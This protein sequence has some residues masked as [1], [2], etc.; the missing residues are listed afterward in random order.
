MDV[1]GLVLHS[2]SGIVCGWLVRR[3]LRDAIGCTASRVVV[4]VLGG[5]L[6]A[7]LMERSLPVGPIS[8]AGAM[9]DAGFA[10]VGSLGAGLGGAAA[11]A[12]LVLLERHFNRR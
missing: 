1:G 4:A 10:V 5:L 7:Q 11:I 9:A 2:L 3:P 8:A 6:G 12:A